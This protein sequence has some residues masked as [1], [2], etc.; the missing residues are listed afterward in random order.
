MLIVSPSYKRSTDVKVRHWFPDAVLAVHEFEVDEYEKNQGGKIMVLPDS[1]RGNMAKVRQ[2]ILDQAGDDEWVVMMDDDVEEF[3][4][5]GKAEGKGNWMPYDAERFVEFL[6][7]GCNMAE[8]LGT[9]LWGVNVSFDPR[10]FREYT[11]FAF[12]SP[13]LG[14]FCVQKKTKGINYDMRLGLKE[15]YDLFLQH[16]H[17][18][19]KVLRFNRYYYKAGHLDVAGGCATYRNMAEEKKQAEIFT[20]KWGSKVIKWTPERSTNPRLYAPIPGV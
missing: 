1:T 9:N 19:H 2:F 18:S 7:V 16:L 11:P 17:R 10:F 4:D 6:E 8:E 5:F 20:K 13:V 12:S 15:D 3:G 14:T